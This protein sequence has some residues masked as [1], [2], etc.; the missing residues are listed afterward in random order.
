[1]KDKVAAKT[2]DDGAKVE[3]ADKNE[4]DDASKV[5][6]DEVASEKTT[7]FFRYAL[8]TQMLKN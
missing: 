5:K 3:E 1:M 2:H 8:Q 6:L 4:R 7:K